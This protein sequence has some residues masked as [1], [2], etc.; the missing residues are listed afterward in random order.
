MKDGIEVKGNIDIDLFL[1][2]CAEF[3]KWLA[4]LK[5]EQQRKELESLVEQVKHEI[6]KEK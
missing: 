2:E 1:Q 6:G 3:E 4:E 5:H